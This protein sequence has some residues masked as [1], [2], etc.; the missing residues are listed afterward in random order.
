MPGSVA[1]CVIP[2][3]SGH[4]L[5]FPFVLCLAFQETRS[6]PALSN[7]YRD[8]TLQSSALVAAPRRTW[9]QTQRLAATDAVALKTFMRSFPNTAFYMYNLIEGTYDATGAATTGRYKARLA[10]DLMEQIDIARANFPV[11]LVEIA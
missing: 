2:T 4:P 9:R 10:G 11:E 3:V 5:V 7:E 1:N 8:G 6:Y